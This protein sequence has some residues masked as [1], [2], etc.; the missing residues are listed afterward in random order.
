[1]SC[2][3]GV[4]RIEVVALGIGILMLVATPL[5]RQV[6]AADETI[7]FD[8]VVTDA[9]ARPI[10]D[11]RPADFELI[12]SGETRP[13]DAVTLQPAGPRV[14]GILLDEFHVRA[15]SATDRAKAALL[16]FVDTQLRDADSIAIVKPLDPLH[17]IAFTQDRALIR[18]L[19]EGFEGHAGDYTPRTEFERNFMSRDPK[20]AEPV[21]AQVVSA[22]LQALTRR[23]ADEQEGRKALIFISEGFRPEQPR[24]IVN[25]ANR[26]RVAIYPIDPGP[27]AGDSD[28]MLQALAVQTSGYASLNDA[29]LTPA[30]AQVTSD[31]DH[32]F[33]VTFT[34]QA[35]EDGRFRPVEIRVKRNGAQARTRA[36]YWTV[37]AELAAAVARAVAP[38]STL[39][40]RPSYSS[41]YIRPWIG[42]SRGDG[43]L[44]RVTITWEPGRTPPRNQRVVAI[45]MKAT[46]GD[47]KVIF[48]QVIGPGDGDRATFEAPPGFVAVEMGIR[49]SSGA[50]LDTDYRALSVPNLQ[51][52]KP[53]FGTPQLL[54]T[55]TARQFAEVSQDPNASPTASR[56]FSRTERLLVRV[57]AY[58]AGETQPV[59]SARLLNR[60]G[61]TMRELQRVEGPLARS[62][63]QFDLPLASLAPDEY[64][65]ELDAANP[66]EPREA[67][68][69]ILLFRVTD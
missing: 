8:V 68:K 12:D 29:D 62:V 43:R 5:I 50:V 47:G 66:T 67:V 40:F 4:K 60:R 1:M 35:P 6:S 56:S 55:R 7:T 32:H 11:L 10:A 33:I 24:S 69:E 44:T 63:A 51:V 23:L 9:K 41:P 46:A 59:I 36:G 42:M 53:T 21:R 27:D 19:I 64:R 54:R 52:T 2:L 18:Q 30:L 37:D 15:G 20:T 13:V 45:V 49:T 65:L 14:F 48:E 38:R 39:P 34:S 16:K 57:P 58:A 61:I 22:A 28:A 25:A 31:L 3:R 26:N 17:A